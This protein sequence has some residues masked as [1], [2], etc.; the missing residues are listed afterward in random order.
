MH[1]E[2]SAYYIWYFHVLLYISAVIWSNLLSFLSAHDPYFQ[3]IMFFC[4][5]NL[6]KE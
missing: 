2:V 5:I 6:T 4:V 3:Q 1:L